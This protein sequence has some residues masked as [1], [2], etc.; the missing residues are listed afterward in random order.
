MCNN[1]MNN[2]ETII[3]IITIINNSNIIMINTI[4]IPK[5]SETLMVSK[6][7]IILKST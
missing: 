2:I 4:I 7:G 3:S 6:F 5:Q 1:I